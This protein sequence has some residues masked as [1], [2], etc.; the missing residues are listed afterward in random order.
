MRV[1][2][3][4]RVNRRY[5]AGSACPVC[6]AMLTVLRTPVETVSR[7]R[8]ADDDREVAEVVGDGFKGERRVRGWRHRA[9]LRC[10]RCDRIFSP[11][12]AVRRSF[13]EDELP[14]D[15]LVPDRG[16]EASAEVLRGIAR[17][18]RAAPRRR[19]APPAGEQGT[20]FDGGGAR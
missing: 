1:P 6:G 19:P 4:Y 15:F 14:P 10:T 2:D 5:A 17:G 11:A 18:L 12:Q 3:G 16:V 13:R 7:E 8:L 9:T 20:L